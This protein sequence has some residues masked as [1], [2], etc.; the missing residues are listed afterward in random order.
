MVK[1]GYARVSTDAQDLALQIE[2]LQAVGCTKIYQ[3]K[4]TGK[5][6]ER[7]GLKRLLRE[8]EDGDQVVVYKL[9]RVARSL[10][11]LLNITFDLGRRGIGFRSL[12]D[13]IVIDGGQGDDPMAQAM[14]EAQFQM[15]GVFAQLERAF[16]VGR[17][18]AGR[19]IAKRKG[20]KFGRKVK[21]TAEQLTMARD[22]LGS[23]NHT[24][25][26]VA[27]SLGVHRSTLWRHLEAV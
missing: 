2:G 12:H 8:V 19:E 15:I 13:P 24:L 27:K 16:I 26:S 22:L 20:V 4:A 21:L 18:S 23:G 9:D 11:D 3:D 6:A 25:A 1:R 5:N 17:T 7:P 14:A 10:R